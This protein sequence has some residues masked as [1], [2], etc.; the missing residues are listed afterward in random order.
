M[1]PFENAA[2]MG[3]GGATVALSDIGCGLANEGQLGLG[4]RLGFLAGTALPYGIE[5]WQSAHFQAIAGIGKF[6]GAGLNIEH[7]GTE[8]YREQRF[9]LAYGRRLAETFYLGG[10]ADVLRAS[11]PEY[12]SLTTATFSLSVLARALPKVWIGA[13]VQNPFQQKIGSDLI[14]TVLRIGATWKPSG[15][16]SLSFETE[17]DLQRKAMIKAGLIYQ[18]VPLLY[19]RAGMRS[20]EITRMAFGAGLKLK[21]NLAIDLASEWHPSL[22]LTPSAMVAWGL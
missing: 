16:F 18:P 4:T 11:A 1:R 12:G 20:N 21:N 5:G 8:D 13:R 19:I 7:S 17:K 6:G 15:L 10:S 9:R 2:A 3:I 22:G 14:P